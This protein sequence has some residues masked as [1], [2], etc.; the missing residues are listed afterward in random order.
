MSRSVV[1]FRPWVVVGGALLAAGN[2]L[3]LTRSGSFSAAARTPLFE[4]AALSTLVGVFLLVPALGMLHQRQGS[5]PGVFGSVAV[6]VAAA[7]TVLMAGVA[8]SQSFLDP[9][10]AQVV[11]RFLDDTPPTVL[12]IGYFASF[13]VFGLG[14]AMYG[15]AIMRAG[16][17]ARPPVVVIVV[18]G[19]VA[20]A[21]FASAAGFVL[22]GAGLVW[23][24]TTA[25]TGRVDQ[26][27]PAGA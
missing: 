9:A 24:G 22:L 16:V 13:A 3:Q 21:P 12:L 2:A 5:Q 23:L 1:P 19:L 7:G 10:A 6:L 11:P 4:V 25:A 17:L 15:V 26:S 8:W 20:A 27:V 14:W 18:G